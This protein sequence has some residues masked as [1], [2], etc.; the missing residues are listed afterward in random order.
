MSKSETNPFK[1]AQSQ[2]DNVAE[3]LQLKKGIH[4]FLRTPRRELSVNFPVRMDDDQIKVLVDILLEL[5]ALGMEKKINDYNMIIRS[6]AM[7]FD[8]LLLYYHNI[9]K[10]LKSYI[11][12]NQITNYLFASL[13]LEARKA[14]VINK[15]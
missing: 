1:I 3:R 12:L 2:L 4:Q 15:F 5:I 13:P 10:N 9:N 11:N 6:I 14:F 7:V 8:V